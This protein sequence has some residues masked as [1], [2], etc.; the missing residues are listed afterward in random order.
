MPSDPPAYIRSA[1]YRCE[2]CGHEWKQ[3]ACPVVC[4]ACAH[5]YVTWLNHP[6]TV[7]RLKADVGSS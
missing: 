2:R 5:L 3:R 7:E 1:H 6:L 4:P